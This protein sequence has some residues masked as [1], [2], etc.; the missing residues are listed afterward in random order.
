MCSLDH[1]RSWGPERTPAV[2]LTRL[3][4]PAIV[5]VSSRCRFGSTR[6]DFGAVRIAADS[7]AQDPNRWQSRLMGA[8][9]PC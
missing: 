3:M 8:C 2:R 5:A 1:S 7:D 9:G 4:Q 6:G